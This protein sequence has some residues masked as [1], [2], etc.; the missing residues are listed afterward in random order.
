MTGGFLWGTASSAYQTEGA[1]RA[2]GKALSNWDVATNTGRVVERLTGRQE[3]ANTAIGSYRRE[4]YLG[5]IALMRTLGLTAHRFS[6]SWARI[7]PEGTGAVNPLAIAHYRRFAE[8]LL[9]AGIAPVVTLYHWDHPVALDAIGGW[10]NPRS[11][12]W[13]EDYAAAVFRGLGDLVRTFLTFNEPFVALYLIEP[14]TENLL[15]GR[16][17][18]ATGAQYARQVV[19]AH[20]WMLAHARAVRA[21]RALGLDG[22]I[23]IALSLS[24]TAPVDPARAEDVAAAAR[25]DG[26]RNRWFL[27]ALLRGDYPNDM[28]ALYRAQGAALHVRAADRALLAQGR[29]DVLGVNYY[30]QAHVQA[31]PDGAF[32]IATVNPDPVPACNG[33]VRP[34]ALHDLLLRIR[35]DYADPVMWI[36]ENGAGF[37]GLDETTED[38]LRGDYIEAHVDAVLRARGAGARVDGYFLWTLCDNFEW[39]WGTRVRFGLVQVD[40]ATLRRTPRPSFHRYA[41]L[42]A[43]GAG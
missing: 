20:H 7:L 28:L 15:A 39:L 16:P 27:D 22:R 40:P 30:A 3:T 43:R 42:I 14:M 41:G 18:R 5:D 29:P 35:N 9:A 21:Y 2:D 36:T 6:L 19:A 24:P 33:P 25:L 11:A 34:R 26:L 12:D 17:A 4:V 10:H 23:G 13:F 38:A 8:D 31:D 32:G 37:S 1:W